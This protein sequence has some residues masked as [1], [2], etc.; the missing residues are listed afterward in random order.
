MTWFQPIR[1]QVFASI[2]VDISVFKRKG[3]KREESVGRQES[4]TDFVEDHVIRRY[5]EMDKLVESV[6][7]SLSGVWMPLKIPFSGFFWII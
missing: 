1:I 7:E 2:A 6:Y 3:L 4:E 5:R